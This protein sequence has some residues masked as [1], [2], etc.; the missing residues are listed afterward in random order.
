MQDQDRFKNTKAGAPAIAMLAASLAIA[1][2]AAQEVRF[3]RSAHDLDFVGGGQASEQGPNLVADFLLPQVDWD[4]LKWVGRPTVYVGGSVNLSDDTSFIGFGLAWRKYLFKDKFYGESNFGY[5]VH[6]GTIEVPA[7]SPTN[8]DAQNIAL[9]EQ[10]LE[11]IEFGSRDLFRSAIVMGYQIRPRWAVEAFF[12][13]LSHGQIIGN[14]SNEGL[15]NL[16]A[17]LAY[18]FGPS[19]AEVRARRKAKRGQ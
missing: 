13:H 4:W 19:A 1:P 10:N 8:T 12:E 5:V 16:G 18:R 2:V 14:G 3:G 6:N 9:I 15:N 11:E 7:L 17:R